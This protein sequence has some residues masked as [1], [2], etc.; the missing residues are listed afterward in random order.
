MLYAGCGGVIHADTGTIKS[1]NY[2]QNFPVNIECSWQ[3]IAHEGN[4]I[5]MSFNSDFQIPDNSGQCQSSY[6]KV[7]RLEN[8]CVFCSESHCMQ[9]Y[10]WLL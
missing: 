8:E 2:P 10:I 6:V 1:P 9:T 7:T 3:I 5:E 4:H